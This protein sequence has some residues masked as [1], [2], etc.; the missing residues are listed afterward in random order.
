MRLSASIP[1]SDPETKIAAV[2]GL[3][4]TAT[5]LGVGSSGPLPEP[6]PVRQLFHE[7]GM[8]L[9]QVSCYTNLEC[10]P[11]PSRGAQMGRLQE[12]LAFAGAAGARCVVSGCG[13]MDPNRADEVFV[14]HPDNWTDAAMDRLAE[15]CGEAAYWAQMAGTVFCVEPW[16]LLTLDSPRRL[17]DLVRR[18]DSAAFGILFDPVNLM[19]L[20]RY[21]DSGR[22]I[23]ETFDLLGD[24][25]R[26]VHAKD[27]RLIE[28]SF[29]FH[30]SEALPG[31][32][33]L[34]YDALL[35]CMDDLGDP[36]TPLHIEHLGSVEDVTSARDFIRSTASRLGIRI[37]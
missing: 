10:A 33:R 14:A 11:G 36:E 12:A 27:T 21:F 19:N 32:G 35:R 8:M 20:D 22:M 2:K 6:V 17:A 16:V 28:S 18:V 9:A 34:D 24:H 23:R 29:T 15:S 25:V 5:D 1:S 13:H 37:T 4:M 30:L 7:Q 26:I 3:G 31:T